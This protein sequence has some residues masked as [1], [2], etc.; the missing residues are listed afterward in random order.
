MRRPRR[1]TPETAIFEGLETLLHLARDARAF[2][3]LT[4]QYCTG[5]IQ[6]YSCTESQNQ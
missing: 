3:T 6:Q 2:P 4:V 1:V 5:T